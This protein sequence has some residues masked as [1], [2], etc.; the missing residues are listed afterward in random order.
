M[1]AIL[2]GLGAAVAWCASTVCSSRSTRMIGPASVVAWVALVGL[3][4]TAPFVAV[5]GVPAR[6]DAGS[7]AWLAAAGVGNLA[8][9]F[10]AYLAY[11]V[12]DVALIAPIVAT[13]GAIAAAIALAS[14]E[15]V[16]VATALALLAVATG[17]SLAA[18]PARDP[19]LRGARPSGVV[20]LAGA[21]AVCFGVSL[22]ATGN[23][24]SRLPVAWVV[25][26]PRVLGTL[27]LAI[28][29]AIGG[30]LRLSRKALPLVAIAG[31]CE[32]LGFASFTLGARHGIAVAAVLSCQFA[33]MSAVVGYVFFHERLART[34]L[35]GVLVVLAGIT[36][37]SGVRG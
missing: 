27:A 32:V 9:L 36:V 30:R 19:S 12:G 5:E 2:G 37:L 34:Q 20:A 31:I 33:A 24:S 14:G 28:P 1:I 16:E 35:A 25:L 3:L 18:M 8:G 22:Y 11:R 26:P 10:I 15:R 4:L 6:L 17:I 29:L 21:A 23:V 7:A 13:E